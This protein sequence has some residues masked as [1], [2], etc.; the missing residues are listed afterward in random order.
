MPEWLIWA[1]LGCTVVV[2]V[3]I[4]AVSGNK[5]PFKKAIGSMVLG[6]LALTVVNLCGAFTGVVLPVSTLSVC[7]AA[8]GGL[9]GVTLMLILNM[10]F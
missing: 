2:F 10:F 5:K 1:I 7:T 3:I 4:Q 9:P 6:L 8:I